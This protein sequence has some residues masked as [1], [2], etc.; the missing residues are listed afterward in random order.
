MFKLEFSTDNAA[1]TEDRTCDEVARIL[2]NISTRMQDVH[3]NAEAYG[4]IRDSN[5]NRIGEWYYEPA[6]SDDEGE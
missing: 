2:F 6:A 1:F 4:V 5:G 3:T